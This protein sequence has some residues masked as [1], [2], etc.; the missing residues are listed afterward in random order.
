[1]QCYNFHNT[2]YG[3]SLKRVKCKLDNHR[4][5]LAVVKLLIRDNG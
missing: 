5:G 3:V 4:M 2:Q 1:M